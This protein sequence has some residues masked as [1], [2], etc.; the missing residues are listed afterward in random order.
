MASRPT[1]MP[2]I[3]STQPLA[4]AYAYTERTVMVTSLSVPQEAEIS[5][6]HASEL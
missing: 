6:S 2:N 5:H 4:K 3:T 1:A